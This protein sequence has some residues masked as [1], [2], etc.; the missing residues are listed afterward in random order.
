MPR[1][2]GNSAIA[3]FTSA[4]AALTVLVFA[5]AAASEHRNGGR[6]VRAARTS[7]TTDCDH[8]GDSPLG[9]EFEECGTAPREPGKAFTPAE[10]AQY[11]EQYYELLK[12]Y[13][14]QCG[15]GPTYPMWWLRQ[16]Y[17]FFLPASLVDACAWMTFQGRSLYAM[18]HDPPDLSLFSVALPVVPLAIGNTPP[19][20]GAAPQTCRR[21]GKLAVAY[22]YAAGQ[23]T[24]AMDALATSLNRL[25]ST[26]S[27]PESQFGTGAGSA[28]LYSRRTQVAAARL[29]SGLLA[30]W[31]ERLNAARTNFVHFLEGLGGEAGRVAKKMPPTLRSAPLWATYHHMNVYELAQLFSALIAQSAPSGRPTGALAFQ[32]E[33]GI[34]TFGNDLYQI[35]LASSAPRGGRVGKLNTAAGK[36]ERD[37]N[38]FATIPGLAG[39]A[40]DAPLSARLFGFAVEGLTGNKPA[41]VAAP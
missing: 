34:Q 40:P 24:A 15:N 30:A 13:T 20:C 35:Y 23:A 12:Q 5:G 1:P 37:A 31:S 2:R 3:I 27:R 6:P 18:F 4:V 19:N 17:S 16:Y 39:F 25:A 8:D 29:Y 28:P 38:K 32:L 7:P 9:V 10:K 41:P 26:P 22:V 14:I 33:A 11:R 36:F 21:G